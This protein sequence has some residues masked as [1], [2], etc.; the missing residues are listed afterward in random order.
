[1]V[2]LDEDW[3]AHA[4]NTLTH[5]TTATLPVTTTTIRPRITITSPIKPP[6][7]VADKLFTRLV[8]D[9]DE[10]TKWEKVRLA[11]HSAILASLGPATVAALNAYYPAGTASLSCLD[12]VKYV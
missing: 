4:K 8:Y 10:Y 1:M 7:L 9:M 5:T 11:L 6:S 12:L 3:D 2:A